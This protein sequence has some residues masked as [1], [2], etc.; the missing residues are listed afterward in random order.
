[1]IDAI[2]LSAKSREQEKNKNK[3]CSTDDA[4]KYIEWGKRVFE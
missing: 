1:M 3:N 2:Q 4:S